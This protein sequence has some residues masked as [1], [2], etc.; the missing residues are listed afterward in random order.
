MGKNLKYSFIYYLKCPID[1]KVKYVGKCANP[2]YRYNIHL[3][4]VFSKE[5]SDWISMLLK[6]NLKPIL[7]VV[8]MCVTDFASEVETEHIILNSKNGNILFNKYQLHEFKSSKFNF[9]VKYIHQSLIKNKELLENKTR[10]MVVDEIMHFY[11]NHKDNIGYEVNKYKNIKQDF[12]RLKKYY[13]SINNKK[14]E[15]KYSR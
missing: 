10:E 3:S 13:E 15:T 5:K 7:E 9:E 4:D 14:N 12:D 2:L 11:F 1:N 8:Q 6:K